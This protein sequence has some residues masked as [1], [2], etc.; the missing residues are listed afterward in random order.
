MWERQRAEF[1]RACRVLTPDLPGF[2]QSPIVPGVTIDGMADTVAECLDVVGVREPAVIGGLSMGGYVALAFARKYPSRLR[3][4]ILADTRAE[5][6]DDTGKANRDKAIAAVKA[7][8]PAAFAEAQISKQ[9]GPNTLKSKPDVVALASRIGT[10]QRAEGLVAALAALRDR[11]DARPGLR[12]VRVPTLVIV[13]EDDAITPPAMADTL[14][15]GIKGSTLVPIPGAGHLSNLENAASFNAALM[16]F[17]T[18]G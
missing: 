9:L 17:L 12:L 14:Q 1:A 18:T 11:P 4:L 2:G 15:T 8:G 16:E 3:G 10:S 5:P 6:D 7:A 13:G